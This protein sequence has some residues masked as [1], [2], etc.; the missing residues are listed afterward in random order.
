MKYRYFSI[1]EH[2]CAV[3]HHMFSLGRFHEFPIPNFYEIVYQSGNSLSKTDTYLA[4]QPRPTL[5]G[6]K[7]RENLEF[8]ISFGEPNNV[9]KTLILSI[10]TH[11]CGF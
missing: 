4:M 3:V 1:S 11:H 7:V 9:A 8:G 6:K 5:I 2:Y 10:S